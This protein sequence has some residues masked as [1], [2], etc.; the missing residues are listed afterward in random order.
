M[1]SPSSQYVSASSQNNLRRK[2]ISPSIFHLTENIHTTFPREIRDL[3]YQYILTPPWIDELCRHSTLRLDKF[4]HAHYIDSAPRETNSPEIPDPI[5]AF[6]PFTR[7]LIEMLYALHRDLGVATP[8]A[9]PAFLATDFFNTGLS[10]SAVKLQRLRIAGCVDVDIHDDGGKRIREDIIDVDTLSSD[11]NALLTCH[12]S[13]AFKLT[14][15]FHNAMHFPYIEAHHARALAQRL[16]TIWQTL[17]SFIHRAKA[18]GAHISATFKIGIMLFEYNTTTPHTQHAMCESEDEWFA[19][20]RLEYTSDAYRPRARMHRH[21]PFVP[22]S[23][24]C[25]AAV[26]CFVCGCGWVVYLPYKWCVGKWEA[27]KRRRS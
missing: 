8:S 26:C 15:D 12:W 2:L 21:S 3:V 27:R 14:F 7:E 10:L 23:W 9:I 19:L 13:P 24:G 25:C 16:H 6:P 20:I 5:P 1:E 11:L 22:F 18:L 4:P 17:A